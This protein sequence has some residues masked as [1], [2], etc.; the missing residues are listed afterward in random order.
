MNAGFDD[1]ELEFTAVDVEPKKQSN[2]PPPE[3]TGTKPSEFKSYR[4]KVKLWLLFTRTP[5]QEQGPRVLSKLTVPAWDACD[6]LEPEDVA[7]S[8]GVNVI[9]D[10]L[11]EAFQ[12]VHEIELFDALVVT[13]YG[14]SKKKGEGLHDHAL[15]VQSNVRELAKQGIRLPDQVQEFLLLLRRANLSTQARIAIM[16]LAGD[17]LRFVDV[18]KACK[19]YA[20]EFSRDPKEHDTRGPHTVFVSQAQEASVTAEE[21][22]GDSDVETALAALAGE[23][24]HRFARNRHSRDTAGLQRVTT[25]AWRTAGENAVTEP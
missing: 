19:R 6:G 11:A 12:G 17:S 1:D 23:K 25:V 14:T 20:D 10:T 22:E 5:A 24:R 7:T 18:R 4:K 15:Q 16:T 21:Q 8:D 13:F 3:F 2:D 9:L